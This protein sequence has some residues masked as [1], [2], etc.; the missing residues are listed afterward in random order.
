[1]FTLKSIHSPSSGATYKQARL[2]SLFTIYLIW[3]QNANACRRVFPVDSRENV[4]SS[5]VAIA[6]AGPVHVVLFSRPLDPGASDERLLDAFVPRLRFVVGTGLASTVF[7][8]YV[9][10]WFSTRRG[11]MLS[12]RKL[13]VFAVGRGYITSNGIIY[14]KNPFAVSNHTAAATVQLIT[15]AV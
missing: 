2:K 7:L 6:R 1:M 13:A 15:Q 11:K 9:V 14:A 5:F 4:V 10:L 12:L 3:P 8:T